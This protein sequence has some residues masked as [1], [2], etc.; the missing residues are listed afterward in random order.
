[1]SRIIS[2][3]EMHRRGLMIKAKSDLVDAMSN[4]DCSLTPMEWVNVLHETAAR[5]IAHGLRDEWDEDDP[6]QTV[7]ATGKWL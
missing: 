6:A 5:I 1:V 4:C 2:N 7:D 3:Y